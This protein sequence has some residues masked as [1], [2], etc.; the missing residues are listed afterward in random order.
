MADDDL[1]EEQI[2]QMERKLRGL[3][4]SKTIAV[5]TRKPRRH[6]PPP[7]AAPLKLPTPSPKEF[8]EIISAGILYHVMHVSGPD[9]RKHLKSIEGYDKAKAA[10]QEFED[11]GLRVIWK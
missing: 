1:T 5:E 6:R 10:A 8:V 7:S 3:G 11:Q 4:K 2:R 9:K